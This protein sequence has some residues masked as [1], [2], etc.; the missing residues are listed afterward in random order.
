MNK[1]FNAKIKNLLETNHWFFR[2]L[3]IT[4]LI[5]YCLIS[6]LVFK[7]LLF[8]FVNITN[9]KYNVDQMERLT[10]SLVLSSFT[11]ILS[12]IVIKQTEYLAKDFKKLSIQLLCAFIIMEIFIFVLA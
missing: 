8:A 12:L 1:K 7:Y 6:Y 4:T 10:F 5:A 11:Y 2:F 3:I 9:L